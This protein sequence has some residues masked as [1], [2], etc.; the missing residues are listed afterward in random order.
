MQTVNIRQFKS[1]PSEVLRMARKAPV[2]I[3]NRDRPEAV[4]FHLDKEGL[5][6]EPGVR[7]AIATGLY[8]SGSVSIGCGAK[9][10]GMAL[11]EFMQAMG[12]RGIPVIRGDA[13]TLR[14]ELKNLKAW[15][16]RK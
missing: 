2:V 16:A 4:L 15:R 13:K 6:S 11:E 14:E 7:L 12:M 1:N 10:A 8:K 3:V 5:L 9:I